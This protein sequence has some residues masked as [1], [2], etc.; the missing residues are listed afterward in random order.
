MI[1]IVSLISNLVIERVDERAGITCLFS[2]LT[3]VLVSIAC[4][5]WL[6]FSLGSKILWRASHTFIFNGHCL[7]PIL[8]CCRFFNDLRLCMMFNFVPCI[9]I[10]ALV[11]LFPPKYTH[12]RFW[13]LAA[14]L[15][16]NVLAS[17]NSYFMVSYRYNKWENYLFYGISS[18]CHIVHLVAM[19]ALLSPKI[20]QTGSAQNCKCIKSSWHLRSL[21]NITNKGCYLV[22]VPC[23]LNQM[24]FLLMSHR[25]LSSVKNWSPCW[26]E[27]L[28]CKSL[29]HQ[30]SLLR[31]L[32]LIYG[33]SYSQHNALVKKYQNCEVNFFP[34]N[35][36]LKW[37]ILS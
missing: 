5:R 10:P 6:K 13:F 15:A 36:H 27:S 31:A 22:P 30:R 18:F 25:V 11:F 33:Y 37:T 3:L 32:V 34:Q 19:L 35:S 16:L 12:S 29:L 9:V 4:E 14:G 1:A 26:Q 24:L 7:I 21:I 28:W 8:A 2:L 23:L 20:V 17:F